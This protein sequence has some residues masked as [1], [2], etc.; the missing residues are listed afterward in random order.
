MTTKN[1]YY[2]IIENK[3]AKVAEILIYGVIGDS[4]FEESTTAKQFVAEFRNLEKNNDRINIRLNSPGGS[5]WDG[6]AICNVISS[7]K[8][9]IH[10]YNDGLC[11]SMAAPIL[12]SV[13]PANVHP[14]KNSLL[15]LHSPLSG[16]R[17]NKK[18]IEAVLTILDKVQNS[19]LITLC[20]RTGLKKEDLE[21]KY[22]DFK[23]HWLTADEAKEEGLYSQVDDYEAENIPQN[24]SKM[25]LLDLV[26]QFEP[27]NSIFADWIGRI[28]PKNITHTNSEIDMNVKVLAKACGLPEDA[29]EQDVLDWIEKHGNPVDETEETEE[30]Q[31]EEET[32]E[33]ETTE[34][35]EELDPKDQE[36]A[37]LKAQMA[38]LKKAPGA[39]DKKVV[40]ST[41]SK[42][43]GNKF[44]ML[45]PETVD[46][47]KM[48]KK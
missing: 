44:G 5:V 38:A 25:S 10:T 41:D 15:M 27:S 35:T 31:K 23:D 1:K 9:S 43:T 6:L 45:S 28:A 30:T 18:D 13:P 37:L 19:L 3:A 40:K 47:Y 14:A 4:W 16:A 29:T 20:D 24:A 32:E 39:K 33:E 26:K 34:E 42:S 2:D 7:S 22:F 11:A 36:I 21:A 48:L 46:L 12:L 17:G 8:T